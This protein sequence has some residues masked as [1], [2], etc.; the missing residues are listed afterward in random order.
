LK[1][2]FAGLICASGRSG[3]LARQPA[4]FLCRRRG[5][6]R[7]DKKTAAPALQKPP[8]AVQDKSG[9]RGGCRVSAGRR[10]GAPPSRSACRC[11]KDAT[12]AGSQ[13]PKK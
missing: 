7:S 13:A 5:L 10:E 8:G 12:N 11:D 4:R 6:R 3:I 1:A 9:A 2:G